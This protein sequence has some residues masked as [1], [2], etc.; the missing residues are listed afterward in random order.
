M[1]KKIP[2]IFWIFKCREKMVLNYWKALS[3][4]LEWILQQLTNTPSKA[5]D[6]A[7]NYILKPIDDQRLA[8]AT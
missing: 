4:W 8:E 2:L 1:K 3:I 5:F 6:D 7:L